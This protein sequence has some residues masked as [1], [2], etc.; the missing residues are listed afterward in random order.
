MTRLRSS[1]G[2][3]DSHDSPNANPPGGIHSYS[4]PEANPGGIQ[5]YNSPEAKARQNRQSARGNLRVGETVTTRPRPSLGRTGQPRLA[6]GHP[7]A[8][9]A[10]TTRQKP[11][12]D[13][14]H[15]HDSP[16]TKP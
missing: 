14:R 8:R 12:L 11:T 3:T 6:R 4:S 15:S 1:V 9:Q 10:V 13:R 5:S 16:E 2:G 7:L